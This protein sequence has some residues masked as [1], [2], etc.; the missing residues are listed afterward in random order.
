MEYNLSNKFMDVNSRK[1]NILVVDDEPDARE[2]FYEFISENKNYIVQLGSDGND[3]LAKAAA[4]KFDLILLDIVMPNKDGVE[5]L[6]E[7]VKK[8]DVFGTPRI[9]MLTNIGGDIAVEEALK[10]GAHGYKLK[11]DTE[12][13]ELMQVIKDELSK[14]TT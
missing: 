13:D 8:P 1:W 11:L 4:T 5:V 6:N 3:A 9:I 7:L 10:L 14:I 2:L 12:P